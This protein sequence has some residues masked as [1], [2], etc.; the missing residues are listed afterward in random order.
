MDELMEETGTDG[1]LH[2]EYPGL[3]VLNNKR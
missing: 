2:E 3:Y 1:L